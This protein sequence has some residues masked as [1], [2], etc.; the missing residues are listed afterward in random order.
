MQHNQEDYSPIKKEHYFSDAAWMEGLCLNIGMYENYNA[1][2]MILFLHTYTNISIKNI[3]N[4]K[5]DNYNY[6]I[7]FNVGN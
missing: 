3:F 7:H 2:C 4:Y 6:L 5:Q 1:K